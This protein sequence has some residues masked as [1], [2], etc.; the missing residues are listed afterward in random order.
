MPSFRKMTSEH[1]KP[2]N[3]IP[4]LPMWNRRQAPHGVKCTSAFI[5]NHCRVP[6]KM[7]EC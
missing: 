4:G 6:Y 5:Q 2:G 7:S 3:N 1:V